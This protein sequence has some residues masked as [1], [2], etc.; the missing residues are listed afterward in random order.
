M[1]PSA[2]ATEPQQV[3]CILNKFYWLI[4]FSDVETCTLPLWFRPGNRYKVKVR[5]YRDTGSRIELVCK[6]SVE[7]RTGEGLLL[8]L[9][10]SFHAAA[11]PGWKIWYTAR[12]RANMPL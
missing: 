4:L 2:S 5:G 12:W 1:G 9:L 10:T 7:F 6:K 11:V 3:K 8:V